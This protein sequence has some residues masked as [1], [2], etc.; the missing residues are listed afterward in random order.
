MAAKTYAEMSAEEK[1]EID[2]QEDE[3]E[4]RKAVKSRCDTC[5]DESRCVGGWI[6][7]NGSEYP[8][9]DR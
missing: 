2:R 6:R 8:C 1:A 7:W 4:S 5:E 9:S 3:R